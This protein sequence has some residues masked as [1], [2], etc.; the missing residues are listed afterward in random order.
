MRTTNEE[1]QAWAE[2]AAYRRDILNTPWVISEADMKKYERGVRREHRRQQ[3][4][5]RERQ[6]RMERE[7]RTHKRSKNRRTHPDRDGQLN[8][9][10]K[11]GTTSG[12]GPRGLNGISKCKN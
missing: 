9:G 11:H 8:E 12:K 10:R 7:Q 4:I 3:E 6:L 1:A 2:N 5:E